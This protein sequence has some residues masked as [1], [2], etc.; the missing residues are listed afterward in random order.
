MITRPTYHG[1][2]PVLPGEDE[3]QAKG[4]NTAMS[5]AGHM[6]IRPAQGV[7]GGLHPLEDEPTTNA[8]KAAFK[9]SQGVSD[10]SQAA[11]PSYSFSDT[12]DQ[13][14]SATRPGA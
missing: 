13:V 14:R 6:L 9:L 2:G 11:S 8:E 4:Q 3:H 7:G 5:L 10:G 12:A 1:D